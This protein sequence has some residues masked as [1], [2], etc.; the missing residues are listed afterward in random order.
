[1]NLVDVPEELALKDIY[2]KIIEGVGDDSHRY[3]VRFTSTPP[4]VAS[5]FQALLQYAAK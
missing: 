3:V 4:E 5:Y 1:M 2:G